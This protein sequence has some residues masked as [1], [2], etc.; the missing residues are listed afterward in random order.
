M[1]VAQKPITLTNFYNQ[2]KI[3]DRIWFLNR[4]LTEDLMDQL[5]INN[6]LNR[7]LVSFQGNKL[8]NGHRWYNYKE[9]FQ[10]N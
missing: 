2:D 9:G 8:V 3:I 6:D 4:L 5:S 7:R 10:L 1:T